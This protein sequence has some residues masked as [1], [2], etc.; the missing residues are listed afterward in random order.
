MIIHGFPWF[1]VNVEDGGTQEG[2]LNLWEWCQEDQTPN[3]VKLS[4]MLNW[5]ENKQSNQLFGARL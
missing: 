3:N 2:G 5:V 1:Y 4:K